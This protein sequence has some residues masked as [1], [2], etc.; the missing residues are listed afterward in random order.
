M[1]SK[2]SAIHRD[3]IVHAIINHGF[4]AKDLDLQQQLR[5]L[6]LK[7]FES[8]V[9][10]KTIDMMKEIPPGICPEVMS[11]YITHSA[12]IRNKFNIYNHKV[13]FE[14][15]RRVPWSVTRDKPEISVRLSEDII[16]HNDLA[17]KV[18]EE[19]RIAHVQTKAIVGR[20]ASIAS[21]I[22]TWP[23]IEK[24]VEHLN[25]A[26]VTANLPI[27]TSALNEQLGLPPQ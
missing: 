6:N 13:E 4:K 23:E 9:S 15:V 14:F 19:K 18:K 16:V 27:N 2:I 8:V 24:I 20:S 22:K 5:S 11:F 21:L 1:S 17:E 3:T 10:R 25:L 7:I 26:P 12:T